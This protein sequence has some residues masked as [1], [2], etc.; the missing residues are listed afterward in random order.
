M[1]LNQPIIKTQPVEIKYSANKVFRT[2]NENGLLGVKYLISNC[3]ES[4]PNVKRC[5]YLDYAGKYIND[6][7][8]A[9]G[10]PSTEF[11]NDEAL[12][13]R[14]NDIFYIPNKITRDVATDYASRAADEIYKAMEKLMSE[15]LESS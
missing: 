3:Y 11:F 2:F 1:K 5:L 14:M 12:V 6:V 4:N 7:G 13:Q 10:L 9:S 15:N 8:V